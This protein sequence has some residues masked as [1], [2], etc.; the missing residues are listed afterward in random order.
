MPKTALR[1][2]NPVI[3]SR[4]PGERGVSGPEPGQ[5]R[6]GNSRD[7]EEWILRRKSLVFLASPS[8]V[9]SGKEEAEWHEAVLSSLLVVLKGPFT[10]KSMAVGRQG[11]LQAPWAGQDEGIDWYQY[12]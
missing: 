8:A 7:H 11:L 6:S 4:P 12:W 10:A 2:W 9:I 5:G 3:S 1:K